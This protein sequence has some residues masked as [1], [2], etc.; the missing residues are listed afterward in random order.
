[1]H[2]SDLGG[3]FPVV[4]RCRTSASSGP[5]L[6]VCYSARQSSAWRRPLKRSDV[7]R[8]A[9]VPPSRSL[10]TI[11]L[12]RRSRVSSRRGTPFHHQN[13]QCV[14]RGMTEA[15]ARELLGMPASSSF[16]RLTYDQTLE[17]RS[18]TTYLG[19]LR[20]P[21][22]TVPWRMVVNVR[23]EN[24]RVSSVEKRNLPDSEC[25]AHVPKTGA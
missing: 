22:R 11:V 6:R 12:S 4:S 24:G 5:A 18:T 23:L 15:E 9:K 10:R 20:R 3:R 19:I 25:N 17:G 21:Y 13:V 7:R 8:H 14:S 16:D 2:N 1:M